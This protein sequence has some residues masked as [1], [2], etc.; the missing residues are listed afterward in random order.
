[1]WKH[2]VSLPL[3]VMLSLK[4]RQ[5]VRA[6]RYSIRRTT[7]KTWN[8]PQVLVRLPLTPLQHNGRRFP[9]PVGTG[10]FIPRQE[11]LKTPELEEKQIPPQENPLSRQ[12]V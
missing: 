7:A 5:D 4:S 11:R 3:S 2:S 10:R 1:M 9:I 8:P 12:S 6:Q